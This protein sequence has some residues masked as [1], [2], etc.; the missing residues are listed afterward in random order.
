MALEELIRRSELADIYEKVVAGRRLSFE[1]G[2]RLF[3]SSDLN[4]IG[5]MAN[6]VRERVNGQLAYYVRNQHI[7]YT[8]ICNKFCKFCAFYALPGDS[9]AYTMSVADIRRKVREQIHEPIT[10]I[11][12]VAGINPRLPYQYYLDILRAIK[13]ERPEVHI[14]AF[15]MIELAQIAKVAKK[16]LDETLLELKEAGLD[17]LPGGGAEVFSE[18]VHK[19][20][21]PLKI[22]PDEWLEIAR[23]AHRL[24]LKSNATM[25]YGH[26]ETSEEKVDHLIRL[27]ALQDETGGFLAF[28]P[29]AFHPE[30]TELAD[31]PPTTGCMDLKH[32]AISRL[33]LD[34]IPHIKAYWIMVTPEV[35]QVSLWYGADDIDGTVVEEKIYHDAGAQTP[36]HLPRREL[37]RM[38]REA[39][40]IPVERDNLYNVIA[41]DG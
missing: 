38:I 6:I 21:Y 30:N 33:M 35:S 24:G 9:R 4:L 31:I 14:K 1:D 8:N 29:L 20:L 17:S 13:D 11:H 12:M 7:N 22:G 34:N 3:A 2:V 27:R 19:E 32:I 10:E 18:R 41:Y 15:T 28:I 16:P 5:L 36:Q 40:R 37:V 25:L 39:G 23:T 26:I